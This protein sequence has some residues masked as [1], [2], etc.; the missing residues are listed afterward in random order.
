VKNLRGILGSI[1]L[2]LLIAITPIKIFAETTDQYSVSYTVLIDLSHTNNFTGVESLV[3]ELFDGTIYILFGS[4]KEADSL[5]PYI[6]YFAKIVYGD[7]SNFTLGDTYSSLDKLNPDLTIIPIASLKKSFS[8]DEID[9]LKKYLAN[10]GRTLWLSAK[11]IEDPKAVTEINKL[12]EYLGSNL[13]IDHTYIESNRSINKLVVESSVRVTAE[14]YSLTYG[15]E[16]ILAYAPSPVALRNITTDTWRPLTETDLRLFGNINILVVSGENTSISRE[17][18]QGRAY[19]Y[20]TSPPYPIIVSETLNR[21]GNST[22]IVSG[23]LP[24]GGYAPLIT[25]KFGGELFNGPRFLRNIVL[26]YTG[27]ESEL[28]FFTQI[29]SRITSILNELTSLIGNISGTISVINNTLSSRIDSLL[30]R[31]NTYD[32]KISE[33]KIRAENLSAETALILT[34]LDDLRSR[35][36]DI[37]SY[38]YVGIGLSI[39]ALALSITS[40]IRRK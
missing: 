21:L 20:N 5:D 7:L 30:A 14:T 29:N 4:V 3:H 17:A 27:F 11:Y 38:V 37:R 16:K 28:R 40:F 15:V 10:G 35:V 12:L 34:K 32:Q 2:V 25:W 23:V 19:T 36:D 26:L 31:V 9:S 6:K 22:L 39:V 1:L 8:A 18:P 33:A 24:I 13:A